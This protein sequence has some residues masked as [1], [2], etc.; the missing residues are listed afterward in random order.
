LRILLMVHQFVP[1]Y[2]AGTEVL[3]FHTAQELRARGDQVTVFTAYP[4]AQGINDEDRFDEYEVEGIPVV[5]FRHNHVPMGGQTNTQEAEYN[6]VFVGKYLRRNLLQEVRP[7]VVH[8]FHLARISASAIDA[9]R[10]FGIPMVLTPTDFWFVCPTSHLRLPDNSMCPGPDRNSVNCL[11]HLVALHQPEGTRS[12]VDAMPDWAL[13]LA[14]RGI[15][16]GWVPGWFAQPVQVLSRRAEFLRERMNAVD[17]VLAPTRL[18]ETTLKRNGLSAEKVAFSPYGIKPAALSAVSRTASPNLRVGFIGTIYEHKGPHLLVQAMQKLLGRPVELKIYG[19]TDEFPEYTESLRQ[20]AAGDSR[21]QF[22]G[23]FPNTEIGRVFSE[24]DVL[25]VPSIWYENAPLVIYS[26]QAAKCPVIASNL[27]G[28]SEVIQ[29]EVNGLLFTPGD[30]AG[31]A[32]AIERL[33]LDRDLAKQL[34]DRS[35]PPRS[36]AQYVTQLKDV[37]QE[38]IAKP[39][40][41]ELLSHASSS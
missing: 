20:M 10:A 3:T 23:T 15:N 16:Q 33:L 37:Y 13:G 14:I 17:R 38:L 1:D 9:C 32:R 18:M 28:M 39:F 11:R 8:F 4:S 12:K 6:N 30:V 22:C 24:L 26:A 40:K 5:R 36:I 7:D 35:R 21:I 41:S 31:L 27:G 34:S 19:R 29:H 25:V 2:V